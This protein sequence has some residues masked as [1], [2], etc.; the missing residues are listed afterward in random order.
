MQKRDAAWTCS[1]GT[2]KAYCSPRAITTP[3]AMRSPAA[4][5]GWER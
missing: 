5:A 2:P 1:S 3:Q 4:P